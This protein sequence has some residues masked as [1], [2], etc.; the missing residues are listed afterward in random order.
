MAE[1]AWDAYR[2]SRIA[3]DKSPEPK[4]SEDSKTTDAAE[5]SR[6]A[7]E[8]EAQRIGWL[9]DVVAWQ[10]DRARAHLELAQC[11]LRLFDMIQ[12][13]SENPM[14]L[15][16]VRDASLRS[17]FPSR[18]ALD[19]WLGRAVGKHARYLDLALWHVR[20]A[21]TL[22]PLQGRAYLYLAELCFLEN[23]G[24]EWK[25]ACIE[26]ALRVRPFDGEVQYA[27]AMEALL[28]GD[29]DRWLLLARQS[30]QC[31]RH[32][33]RKLIA[34]LIGRAAPEVLEE[35]IQVIVREFQPDLEAL[36]TVCAAAEA[37]GQP[38]QLVW[39]WRH[40]AE[41]AEADAKSSRGE[42]A[43][44]LWSEARQRYAA[45]GDSIRAAECAQSAVASDPQNFEARYGLGLTLLADGRPA[46]A[47]PHLRWCRERRPNDSGVETKWKEAFKGRLDGQPETAT[48]RADPRRSF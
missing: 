9:R 19:A 5:A 14:S 44:L 37:R 20:R 47:E 25:G 7:Q 32:H 2:K 16:N 22:C 45:I 26:Q 18:E 1:P 33:Q 21:V 30:F 4:K 41:R 34:D 36:R 28:A 42:A 3:A 31:G 12:A 6:G 46:E 23:A 35:V 11:Y 13:E 43:A 15:G 27:A 48:R 40:C 29:Y 38:E 39:L 8:A 24:E 10:P 17:R